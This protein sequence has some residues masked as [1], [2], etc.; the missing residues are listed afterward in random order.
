M[1][2]TFL[3]GWENQKKITILQHENYV[4][5]QI[6]VSTNKDLLKDSCIIHL[7][8]VYGYF[9]STKTKLNSCDRG[10]VTQSLKDL[11]SGFLQDKFANPYYRQQEGNKEFKP[12]AELKFKGVQGCFQKCCGHKE[13]D[14]NLNSFGP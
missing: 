12:V 2:F 1:L 9:C 6:S 10:H 14:C 5:I 4:K 8:I 11:L 3:N 7:H 13:K